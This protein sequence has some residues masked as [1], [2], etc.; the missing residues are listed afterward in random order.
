MISHKHKCIFIHIPKCAG[1]TIKYLLFPDEVISWKDVDY[2]KLHGWCPER[3]FFMQ[4]ATAHQLLETGLVSEE[5]WNS[6]CKFT[7]VRNPWDRAVSDYFWMMND[8]K[9]KDSFKNYL[10]KQGRFKAILND[11][12]KLYYRGDHTIPQTDFFDTEGHLKMDFIGRFENFNEDLALICKRIGLMNTT[13]LH[14]NKSKKK[15][16][17]YSNYYT[18]ELMTVF[19]QFYKNDIEQFDYQF[20]DNKERFFNL[21][22][23]LG[24]YA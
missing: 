23:S 19:N 8:R 22:K 3:N 17:H 21:K 18:K 10:L 14:I 15:K 16:V 7:F 13:N 6:Y 24:F 12:S 4:H 5:V 9:V 1:T 11:K 20:E 2:D